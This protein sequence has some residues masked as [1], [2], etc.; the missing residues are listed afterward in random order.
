MARDTVDKES[1]YAE[2]LP[3]SYL[4]L[5]EI[6]HSSL[7][8]PIRI[9]ANPDDVIFGSNTYESFPFSAN[10]PGDDGD[11]PGMGQLTISNVDYTI[12]RLI[13]TISTPISV[14]LRVVLSTDLSDVQCEYLGLKGRSVPYN[15]STIT[16]QLSFEDVL[17]V[18]FPGR[19]YNLSTFPNI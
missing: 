17:N 19:T 18:G 11:K 16:F 9:V 3:A 4:L 14:N 15:A 13:R 6:D 7:D 12:S 2:I 8:D 5:V 10:L 1:L